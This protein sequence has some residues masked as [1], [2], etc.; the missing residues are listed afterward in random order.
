MRIAVCMSGHFRDYE[1]KI[2]KFY[3]NVVGNHDCDFFVHS[4]QDSLGFSINGTRPDLSAEDFIR[5]GGFD[6]TSPPCDTSTVVARLKPK[7]YQF[8]TY[9]EVEPNIISEAAYYTRIHHYDKPINLTSM[10]RKIYLCDLLRR[11]YE[12]ENN[13][14]YDLVIRTR[15]DLTFDQAIDFD[16]F[17]LSNLHTPTE[18]SYNIISDVFGFSNSEIMT[19]YSNLYVNL[20]NLH[21][22]NNI[23]FNP[24]ELLLGWIKQN[25]IDF[26]QHTFGIVLR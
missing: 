6:K 9:S 13:F 12:T 2:D 21:D 24:H 1:K 15:P 8:E 7:K 20:K 10:Q 19:T 4:W 16:K 5:I 17:D 26:Q 22:T 11:E 23:M 18:V 3:E 25:N 14:K